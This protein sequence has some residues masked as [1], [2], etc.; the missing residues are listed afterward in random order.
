VL[1]LSVLIVAAAQEPAR[2][3]QYLLPNLPE[4]NAT[5]RRMKEAFAVPGCVAVAKQGT[6]TKA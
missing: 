2:W 6:A 1:D 3:A 4:L 5:A